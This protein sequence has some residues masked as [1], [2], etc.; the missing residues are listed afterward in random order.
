M[1]GHSGIA[2]RAQVDGVKPAQLLEAVFRHHTA[3]LGVSLATPIETLPRE[4]QIKTAPGRLDHSN[5]FGNYFSSN[6]VAFDH[7]YFVVLQDSSQSQN[8]SATIIYCR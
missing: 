2:D 4:R 5:A 3:S 6:A 8:F 7:R 1:V